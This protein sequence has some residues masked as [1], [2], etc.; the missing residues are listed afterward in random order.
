MREALVSHRGK[1]LAIAQAIIGRYR[2]AEDVVSDCILSALQQI[3][4]GKVR[5]QCAAQ[6][7]AWLNQIVRFTARKRAAQP[8]DGDRLPP[9]AGERNLC[10][11]LSKSDDF[12]EWAKAEGY[13]LE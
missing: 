9:T 2:A 13:P 10:K 11:F 8:S 4:A 3:D 1:M 6:F 7:Y 5:A 12:T